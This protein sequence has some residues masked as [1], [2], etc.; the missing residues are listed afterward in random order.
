MRERAVRQDG[1]IAQRHD[2]Q[3]VPDA[4]SKVKCSGDRILRESDI[5]K[6]CLF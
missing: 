1:V 2:C 6:N 4:E 5:V 3:V